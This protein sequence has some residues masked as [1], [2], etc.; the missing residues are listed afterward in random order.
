[1]VLYGKGGTRKKGGTLAYL[2]CS[3][4][5]SV[6]MAP[7]ERSFEIQDENGTKQVKNDPERTRQALSPFQPSS[8]QGR[9]LGRG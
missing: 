3:S 4:S 2:H 9:D 5:E 6:R 8:I 7:L 1:M